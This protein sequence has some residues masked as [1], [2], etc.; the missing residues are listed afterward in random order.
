LAQEPWARVIKLSDFT[1]NGVGIIHTVGP[2]VTRSAQKYTSAVP[3][4]RKLLDRPD[5]PLPEQVKAHIRGQ[6]DVAA[7]RFTVILA[8]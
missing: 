4:L 1:D 8:A 6:L 2:K 3:V 7:Q 5:T